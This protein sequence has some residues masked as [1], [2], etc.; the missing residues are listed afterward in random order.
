MVSAVPWSVVWQ[1]LNLLEVAPFALN[2]T[3]ALQSAAAQDFI[4]ELTNCG[5]VCTIFEFVAGML[6]LTTP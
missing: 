3:N 1:L 6:L 5:G 4:A 2:Q